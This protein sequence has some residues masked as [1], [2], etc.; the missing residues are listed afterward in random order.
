MVFF[1]YRTPP[2]LTYNA[3]CAPC[4]TVLYPEVLTAHNNQA[5]EGGGTAV[6]S[7]GRL[8]FG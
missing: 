7:Q 8:R 2:F 4:V 6:F 1:G 3:S 5:G